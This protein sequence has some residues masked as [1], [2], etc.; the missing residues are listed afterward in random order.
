M[1]QL[2]NAIPVECSP[3][4]AWKVIADFGAIADWLP[5]AVRSRLEGDDRIIELEGMDEP[6][7][8]RRRSQ[9]DATRTLVYTIESSPLQLASYQAT[10]R[11]EPDGDGARITWTMEFEPDEVAPIFQTTA[12]GALANLKA[13]LEG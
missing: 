8:E 1:A 3:D 13:H 2:T 11:V 7:V 4:D 12:E 10:V 5:M 6:I 9:D